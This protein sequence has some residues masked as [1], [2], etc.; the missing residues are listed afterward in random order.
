MIYKS[1][2]LTVLLILISNPVSYSAGK[3]FNNRE[4]IISYD[5]DITI[6]KDGSMDVVEVIKVHSQGVKIKR[7]I[8]RD[9]P[10]KYE[11]KYGNNIVIKFE[12][13]EI[14]RD[15]RR[16][17]YHTESQSN[18]VRVYVGESNIFLTPGDYAYSIKYKTNRQLGF[19]E[20]FDELYWN[21]TGN[22]WDFVIEKASAVVH[23]P[24]GINRSEIKID[25]FTGYYG[26][27][28]KEY[29]GEVLSSSKVELKTTKKL[30]STEGF[31]I[32][33]QFPK[34]F[35]YEP[36]AGD[37]F[38]YFIQDNI[39]SVIGLLG[40]VILLIYYSLIWLKV[41]KDPL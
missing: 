25:G 2:I 19:F 7:G 24:K 38:G 37:K 15:G 3:Q 8:F 27:A 1:L 18:G 21:V 22:G 6:N 13:I 16:E 10:T 41:G 4:R 11:D 28:G 34:G 14:L 5:S 39:P 23:L 9:F 33:V 26:S 31:T 35:V 36:T 29:E 30:N 40:V 32:L 17:S 20:D 12:V